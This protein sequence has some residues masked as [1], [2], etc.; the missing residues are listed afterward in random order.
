M[1]ITRAT[2]MSQRFYA[3][4]VCVNLLYQL[5]QNKA[6]QIRL[7]Q[8]QVEDLQNN[9]YMSTLEIDCLRFNRRQLEQ[10]ID[11]LR[12]YNR[13]YMVVAIMCLLAALFI[14]RQ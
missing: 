8:N 12:L 3:L 9:I 11:T 1:S 7:L 5:A 14:V 10:E 13:I 2:E 6:I 4:L